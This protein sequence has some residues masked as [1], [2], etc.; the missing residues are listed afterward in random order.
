[1]NIEH[2]AFNVN[3]PIAVAEWYVR[4]LGLQVVRKGEGPIFGHF[5]ADSSGKTVL[6]IYHQNAPVPDYPNQHPFVFHIAFVCEDVVAE[7]GRLLAA[8]ATPAGDVTTA[9]NGDVLAFLRDPW[10][11]VLQ[12]VHRKQR[13]IYRKWRLRCVLFSLPSWPL[14]APRRRSQI[15]RGHSPRQARRWHRQP[16]GVL[17]TSPSAATRSSPSGE[18]PGRRS[19]RLTPRAWSSRLGL[20]TCIRIQTI[21]CSKTEMRRAKCVKE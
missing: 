12:L 15:R 14:P 2:V 4:N 3:D 17:A 1:M 8:G 20:S 7:R 19:A 10:G 9:A 5:L 16:V 13:L 18:C 21:C 11:I 6:E